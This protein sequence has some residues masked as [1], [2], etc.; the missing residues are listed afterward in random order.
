[1][2]RSVLLTVILAVALATT[3]TA[4]TDN[5]V[6]QPIP[7]ATVPVF[8]VLSRQGASLTPEYL[9]IL[10][11][12]P[13]DMFEEDKLLHL[14]EDVAPASADI[15]FCIDLTGSMGGELDNVRNNS[16][17][18][19][20][21]VSALIPDTRFGVISHMDYTGEHGGCGYTDVYGSAIDGDY[22]YSL[23]QVL[24]DDTAAVAAALNALVLGYGEDGPEDYTR[25]LY[26]TYADPLVDW[27]PTAQKIVLQWGDNVPHDCA[28]DACIGG[29]TTSGPD[30]GRDEID[31]NGDD[32]EILT[33]LNDMAMEEIILLALHSGGDLALWDCYASITGGQAFEINSDG[34]IP[35]GTD[36]AEFIADIVGSTVT[37]IDVMTLEICTPGYEDWMV[38]LEPPEYTDLMLGTPLDLPFVITFE[39]PMGTMPGTYCFEVCAIGDGVEYASQEVCVEVVEPSSYG[40][41]IKPTSCP[42]PLN[43][44]SG[45]VLPV[46]ILGTE[47]ADVYDIDPETIL[48][49]GVEPLRWLIADVAAPVVDP[50]YCECT[51]DGPD[52][53][54]DLTLKFRKQDIVAAL[55]PVEDDD[56]I[57]LV[58]TAETY[59][60]AAVEASDCVW[61]LK[62]GKQP[63]AEDEGLSPISAGDSKGNESS[64]G[65]IKGLYR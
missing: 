54:M 47:V 11:A 29:A 1:M 13:G 8:E 16:I 53:Y 60:G 3:G 50:E 15:I 24:T 26:E 23:D 20:N 52:G 17:N 35:G 51:T 63:E 38:G 41:D 34:T 61:I 19:M 25:P 4:A 42:N 5:E 22:P 12:L 46:A 59:D 6:V 30:P 57:P 49:E 55:G 36:I 58:L 37:E 56:L 33:V 18:I 44:K 62:R 21:A 32:L 31:G 27:R 40:L 2:S 39:V 9:E 14:P 65:V 43:V 10:G 28:Y 45:G 64:W 7:A 48:L